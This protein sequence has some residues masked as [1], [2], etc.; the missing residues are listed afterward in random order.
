MS[1]G[2]ILTILLLLIFLTITYLSFNFYNQKKQVVRLLAEIERIKKENQSLNDSLKEVRYV[3]F[4][5]YFLEK[6]KKDSLTNLINSIISDIGTREFVNSINFPYPGIHGSVPVFYTDPIILVNEKWIL[7]KFTDGHY[8]GFA[9]LEYRVENGKINWKV[10][11][12]CID[13]MTDE[14]FFE[15]LKDFEN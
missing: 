4:G 12:S 15:S 1:K 5:N 13:G 7:A 3:P 10:I 2:K 11:N 8:E 14:E 9:L 6:S